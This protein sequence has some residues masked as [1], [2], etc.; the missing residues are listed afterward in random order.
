MKKIIGLLLCFV[1]FEAVAY[2]DSFAKDW[3]WTYRGDI[4]GETGGLTL[5]YDQ[6]IVIGNLY[7]DSDY[8][9]IPVSGTRDGRRIILKA[10]NGLIIDALFQDHND[11]YGD[12]RLN[13]EIIKGKINIS[14][15]DGDIYLHMDH[16]SAGGLDSMYAIG[17]MDNDEMVDE[18]A[19]EFKKAVLNKDKEA[20]ADMN[21][22]PL[23]IDG[24]E[25]QDKNEFILKFNE[26]FYPEFFEAFK[27]AI[28]KNM[29]S[30]YSGVMMSSDDNVFWIW[31]CGDNK[32]VSVISIFT[33]KKK[34]VKNAEKIK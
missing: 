17:G 20:V 24:G 28:P 29:F 11:Q 15:V 32:N 18:F 3:H 26:I 30:K 19:Q 16:G 10:D 13:R 21:S 12:S 14:E 5:V 8:V 6:D 22:Y 9:D 7:F 1:V 27:K 31:I 23:R 34:L 33:D 25:I 2:C 4:A